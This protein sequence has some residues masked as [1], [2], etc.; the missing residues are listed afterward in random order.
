MPTPSPIKMLKVTRSRR[1]GCAPF[2]RMAIECKRS[3]KGLSSARSSDS[4]SF[5]EL[6]IRLSQIFGFCDPNQSPSSDPGGLQCFFTHPYSQAR[7]QYPWII[8]SLDQPVDDRHEKQSKKGGEQ[9][10]ADNRATQWCILLTAATE[11]Q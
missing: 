4:L 3:A 11:A 7:M 5:V 10:P 9:Q 2:D 1:P 8:F 6:F